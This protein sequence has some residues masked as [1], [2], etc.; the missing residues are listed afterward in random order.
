MAKSLCKWKKKDIE[1]KLEQLAQ[2]IESP[3]Y[4]CADCA[5]SA[6][7]KGYLCKAVKMPSG[8]HNVEQEED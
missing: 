4:I 1:K 6:H 5:R 7:S 2:I 3:Q 8:K